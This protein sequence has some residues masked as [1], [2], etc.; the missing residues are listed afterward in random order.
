M[1]IHH[2]GVE[3]CVLGRSAGEAGEAKLLRTCLDKRGAFGFWGRV[4]HVV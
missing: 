4:F 3:L 1:H 2:Q